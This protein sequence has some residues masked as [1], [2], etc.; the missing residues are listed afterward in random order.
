MSE[1]TVIEVN[2]K[3]IAETKRVVQCDIWLGDYKHIRAALQATG[4]PQTIELIIVN[5]NDERFVFRSE[6]LNYIKPVDP[7]EAVK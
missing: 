4:Q 3:P 1:Y 7:P 5:A 2:G 6:R